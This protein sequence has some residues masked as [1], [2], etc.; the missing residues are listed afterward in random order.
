MMYEDNQIKTQIVLNAK[1]PIPSL[2]NAVGHLMQ[3]LAAQ[4]SAEL[5]LLEYPS[6]ERAFVSSISKSPLILLKAKN[7]SQLHALALAAIASEITANVFVGAMFGSS[8]DQQREATAALSATD[9][10]F[11]AVAVIGATAVVGP[12]TKKF[13]LFKINSKEEDHE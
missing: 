2:L 5:E 11:V 4:V 1:Y 8:S 3:G 10:D 13:S 9:H 12:L 7:S 6:L